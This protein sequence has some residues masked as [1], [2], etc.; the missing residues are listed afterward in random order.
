MDW[1]CPGGEGRSNNKQITAAVRGIHVN[2]DTHTNIM[3]AAK[4]DILVRNTRVCVYM[5]VYVCVYTHTVS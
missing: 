5:Y 4:I 1:L 2:T 3:Y